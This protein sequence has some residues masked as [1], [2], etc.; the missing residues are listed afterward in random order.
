LYTGPLEIR[1]NSVVRA[2]IFENGRPVSHQNTAYFRI[3]QNPENHGLSYTV[4]EKDDMRL[5]PDFSTLQPTNRGHTLEISSNDLEL[6]RRN[7]VAAV[8]EGY[9]R[10]DEPGEYTFYLA[11][12][13]GSKLYINGREVVDNDG[14]HGVIEKSG[15]ITLEEGFHEIRVE[16][17]NAGGGYWLGAFY[18]GP[19]IPKQII[20]AN[21]LY[22]EIS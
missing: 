3:L 10:I 18:Q 16:W 19:G 4:Y 17:F 12:D 9:I 13:D 6:T 1:E 7:F 5:L 22:S 20:P 21:I 2:R 15:R 11:S 14:D 8:M